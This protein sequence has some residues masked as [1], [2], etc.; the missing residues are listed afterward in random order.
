MRCLNVHYVS[1]K[2]G[3]RCLNVHSVSAM[4]G[5]AMLKCAQCVCS[6]WEC[7]A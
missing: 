2:M 1:T 5:N 6:E 3:M 4:S 7:D